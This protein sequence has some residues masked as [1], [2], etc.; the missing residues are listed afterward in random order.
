MLSQV[1]A[2]QRVRAMGEDL[3]LATQA[4]SCEE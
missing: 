2:F 4:I 3:F 1:K